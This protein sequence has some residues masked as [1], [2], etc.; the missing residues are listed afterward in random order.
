MNMPHSTGLT[1]QKV[2]V[3]KFSLHLKLSW[4][5]P[6]DERSILTFFTVADINFN[7]T[8]MPNLRMNFN[9]FTGNIVSKM[10]LTWYCKKCTKIVT[11]SHKV[12]T[13][14][15]LKGHIFNTK[16]WSVFLLKVLG[17]QDTPLNLISLSIMLS[18]FVYRINSPSKHSVAW[19]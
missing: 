13:K 19:S 8:W 16:M 3:P 10:Q 1:P 12:T 15:P 17:E 5:G 4:L 6:L 7:Y 2:L 14:L 18:I 11:Q 9:S